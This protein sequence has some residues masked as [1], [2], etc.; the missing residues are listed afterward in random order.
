MRH[1]VMSVLGQDPLTARARERPR[2]Y[3]GDA[4]MMDWIYAV[5]DGWEA[6][7]LEQPAGVAGRLNTQVCRSVTAQSVLARRRALREM[8]SE[9]AD[10]TRDAAVLSV[11]C[12]H[13]REAEGLPADVWGQIG[14]FVAADFD[15]RTLSVVQREF[16]PRVCAVQHSVADFLAGHD[17]AGR[18]YDLIYS[19]GLYD[20]LPP[21][22]G[23]KL[24]RNLFG[25]LRSGGRMIVVNLSE[26]VPD[27]GYLE[28]VM[29]WW[30]IYRDQE[31]MRG[32]AQSISSADAVRR[33]TYSISD[34]ALVVLEIQKR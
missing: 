2:G 14:R 8:I 21:M 27:G 24:T 16:G 15:P 6:V 17:E 23:A 18:G 31:E 11:A 20:Y 29:D 28:A 5:E 4:V 3:P 9:A 19:A 13:L 22:V 30:M 32:L 12:G 33:E 10:T 34:G 1:P 25:R 26:R 7:G